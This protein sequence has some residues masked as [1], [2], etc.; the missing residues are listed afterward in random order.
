LIERRE[1]LPKVSICIP[2]Y[3]TAKYLPFAINSVLEQRF[4][5][6]ELV[7]C[8]DGS[9]DNTPEIC[10]RYTDLRIRYVRLPGKSG[11][12]G[13]F[14]RCLKEAR[15]EFVTIISCPDF[16]KIASEGSA[17]IQSLVSFS[18]RCR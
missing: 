11:Q 10:K 3:N 8:D 9:T 1:P 16:W 13:N 5:D 15:G 4:T 7:I 14:N 2:T 18:E 17:M 6:F 12:A